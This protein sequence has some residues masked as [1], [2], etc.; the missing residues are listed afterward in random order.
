MSGSY[1][2]AFVIFFA[3]VIIPLA[4]MM[5]ILWICTRVHYSV[6][7]QQRELT[8]LYH[9]TE[10]IGKWSM[11]DV[12]VVAILVALVQ[13]KGLISFEPGIAAT[14]FAAVVILTMLS[15]LSFDTRL[16]WDKS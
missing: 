2:V 3:S 8:R 7:L 5:A 10:W 16:I 15:A 1:F 9:I 4:K 11:I 6:K 13:V 12:F 14:S